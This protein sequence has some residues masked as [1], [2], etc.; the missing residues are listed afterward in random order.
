M[1]MDATPTVCP[2]L[3]KVYEALERKGDEELPSPI[4][5]PL[6]KGLRYEFMDGIEWFPIIVNADLSGK[7]K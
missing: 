6:R 7:E 2:C 5:K 3:N 4:L 1:I